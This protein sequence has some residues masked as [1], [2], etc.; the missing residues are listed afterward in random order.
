M[1]SDRHHPQ[2]NGCFY[3]YVARTSVV[4]HVF[5]KKPGSRPSNKSF[6]FVYRILVLKVSSSALSCQFLRHQCVKF[7]GITSE[8]RI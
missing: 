2:E 3:L 1:Q 7:F 5:Y 4:I 8:K 6:L